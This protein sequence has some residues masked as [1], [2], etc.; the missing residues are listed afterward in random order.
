VDELIIENVR[1]FA[2]E[3]RIPLRPLTL[4]VGEN[5]TGKSTFLSLARLAWRVL[6]SGNTPDFNEEPFLLGAFEQIVHRNGGRGEIQ[7]FSLGAAYITDSLPMRLF[8][9]R[10]LRSTLRMEVQAVFREVQ[11]QP[12]LSRWTGRLP[13]DEYE[14]EYWGSNDKKARIEARGRGKQLK[15]TG[16]GSFEALLRAFIPSLDEEPELGRE[17]LY[18]LRFLRGIAET[19]PIACAPIR[20]KPK[21]TYDPMR[22]AW[23][24]E[25]EHIPMLL[26]RFSGKAGWASLSSDL[27]QY[28]K[29]AGLWEGIEVK[30]K[31]N[32]A[33]DPFQ[34]H[35]KIG[36]QEHNLIDV[37]YG[38]SQALPLLIDSIEAP[39]G[40]TLL[41][42]QPEVHLHP[43]AQAALGTFLGKLAKR[44]NKRFLVETHSDHLIDRVR[45]DVRDATGKDALKPEDV[46]LLY[47]ERERNHVNI[48][49]IHIGQNGELLDVPAG[50]RSFFL[51]EERRMLGL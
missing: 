12:A 8:E 10:G 45:M 14:I 3:H 19:T 4:L 21:R 17:V 26:S 35:V 25:G 30:R 9:Q 34:L 33:S 6:E 15:K 50:Y 23:S 7:N 5:S 31:G 28:G 51:T 47:F 46:L 48:H 42:Q 13:R 36:R 40:A 2:G 29:D 1:C 32:A 37:G 39:K 43:R 49:P 18:R 27:A 38:V 20:S 24:P 41:L 16:K 11:G 44:Q 22:E